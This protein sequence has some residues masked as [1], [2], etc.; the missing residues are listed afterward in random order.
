MINKDGLPAL[1]DDSVQRNE[2]MIYIPRVANGNGKRGAILSW[3]IPGN[4]M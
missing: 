2:Q 4:R 3:T 1:T